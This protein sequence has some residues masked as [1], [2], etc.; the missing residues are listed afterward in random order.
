MET[1]VKSEKFRNFERMADEMVES[2]PGNMSEMNPQ[3]A[4]TFRQWNALKSK[5]RDVYSAEYEMRSKNR[6]MSRDL[7]ADG[8][9]GDLVALHNLGM[10]KI[11]K[12]RELG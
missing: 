1:F 12:I 7:R 8:T 2:L 11:K 5:I 9:E 4:K 10:D 6:E 3:Q